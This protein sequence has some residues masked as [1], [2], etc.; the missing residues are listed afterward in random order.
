MYF[1]NVQQDAD[2]GGDL[3]DVIEIGD[4][5][6]FDDDDRNYEFNLLLTHL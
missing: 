3:F 2:V 6:L 5:D 4:A 1:V